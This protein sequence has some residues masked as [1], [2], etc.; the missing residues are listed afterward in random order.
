MGPLHGLKV[1]EM[2]G[3]GPTPF[4]GMLLGDMGADV[5]R[6]DRTEPADLG[7]DFP[8]TF[9]LRNRNK[10]SIAIDLKKPEGVA[11]LMR[12][13]AQADVFTEGFRPGTA[14]RLGIGP[15]VCLR[16]N[17]KLVY[18]RATGWGQ[19][20]PLAK[21]AGHDINYIALTG[22]LNSIGP[23]GGQPTPPLN[24]LGD[25]GG[26]A[27]YM[28]FG[29]LCAVLEAR[30]SGRGQ[31]VDAAMVD[32]VTSLMTVCHALRQTGRLL[33]ERGSNDLDGGA[34]YYSTYETKDGRYVA[35]GAIEAR[36]YAELLRGLAIDPRTMPP[37]HDRSRWSEAKARLANV[38][39]TR[40]RD[41]WIAHFREVDACVSPVLDLDEAAHHPHTE[42]RQSLVVRD[43][44]L[45]P[46]P[47]PR[48]SRTP[49]ELARRAPRR[50]EH[51][52]EVLE[53]LGLSKDEIREGIQTAV[54]M[55][56]E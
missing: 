45:Q 19:D 17:P 18:G 8:S 44:V 35:V 54:L 24:L 37:Q 12:L 51:T 6:V 3:L 56:A 7:I 4:C 40:S 23:A 2:A 28:A 30:S 16:C 5:V 25:Y 41:E 27:L 33:L 55:A 50:G 14:E 10:R 42:A 31:I 46:R 29:I 11:L 49:G 53:A 13:V 47:V 43:G 15:D 48:L 21:T 26:G 9:D 39:R 1:L 52:A 20:G 32:G 34:P 38:F 36:F 22:A